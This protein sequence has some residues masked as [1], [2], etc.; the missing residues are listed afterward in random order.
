LEKEGVERQLH[1]KNKEAV[2]GKTSALLEAEK[3]RKAALKI[4]AVEKEIKA[5]EEAFQGI[6]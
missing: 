6:A 3:I 2:K 5:V 4:G 1:E